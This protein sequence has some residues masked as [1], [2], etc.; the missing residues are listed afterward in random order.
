MANKFFE[1]HYAE[2]NGGEVTGLGIIQCHLNQD[3]VSKEDLKNYAR[4]YLDNL[5]AKIVISHVT[6][7]KKSEYEKLTGTIVS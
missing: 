6:K 3:T 5:E 4:K 7:L 2:M 1:F